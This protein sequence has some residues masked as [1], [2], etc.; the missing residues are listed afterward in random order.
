MNEHN[1]YPMA[2]TPAPTPAT[3]IDEGYI[4]AAVVAS[5]ESPRKRIIQPLHKESTAS[6]QRML[7]ALQPGSYIRPH[8]HAPDRAESI[9]VVS[10]SILYLT[11]TAEGEVEKVL[12]L[13]AGSAQIG[14]DIECG[15]WHSFAALEADTVLCEVKPGPYDPRSDKEFAPWAPEEYSAEAKGYLKALIARFS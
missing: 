11:F 6:L 7:N 3:L 12:Q 4:S 5:R 13:K 15:I 2:L 8:R 14:I 10:G 1:D 9:V